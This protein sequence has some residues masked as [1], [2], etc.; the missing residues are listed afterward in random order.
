MPFGSHMAFRRT[1]NRIAMRFFFPGQRALVKDYCMRCETCQLFA[2]A[3]RNDLNVIE[4]I[5][6]DAS[7]FGHF[8]FD[9]IGPLIQYFSIFSMPT[10]NHCDMGT[11]FTSN[12][13]QL[14]LTR[15]GC[16]PRF[17]TSYHPQSSGLVERTKDTLR[18]IISSSACFFISSFMGND[19]SFRVMELTYLC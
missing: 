10:V 17:N 8:V 11:N 6:R 19:Y 14:L 9:C 7:L 15:L 1:N 5:P 18:I 16:A 13:T 4:P 3:R 2:P 12:L